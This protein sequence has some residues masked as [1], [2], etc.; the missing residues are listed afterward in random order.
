MMY[1]I[2]GPKRLQYHVHMILQTF[3]ISVTLSRNIFNVKIFQDVKIYILFTLHFFKRSHL[4]IFTLRLL[5]PSR[6]G[7]FLRYAI[8]E[9]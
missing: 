9:R 8:S 3:R 6:S 4:N 7:R 2:N 1:M 5:K